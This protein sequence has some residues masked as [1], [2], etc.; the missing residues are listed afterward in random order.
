MTA[1]TLVISTQEQIFLTQGNV[2]A[3]WHLIREVRAI[4][5]LDQAESSVFKRA[6]D[7]N[8]N[9]VN[10]N[11][12]AANSSEQISRAT[13]IVTCTQTVLLQTNRRVKQTHTELTRQRRM[14]L[15]LHLRDQQRFERDSQ[16]L[17]AARLRSSRLAPEPSSQEKG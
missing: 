3:S 16:L 13:K 10:A 5:G 1:Q 11:A 12:R 9:S 14:L 6:M 17:E 2:D 7:N 8:P 15:L 4:I